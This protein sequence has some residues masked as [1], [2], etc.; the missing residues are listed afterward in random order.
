MCGII[1]YVGY[2]NAV[3]VLLYGLQ[4]LEYRGYDS[5]GIAVL[6][7]LNN[8]F[9]IEKKVGKIKDLQEHLW[10]KNIEG[11]IGIG[12]TRW[13]T[14]GEPTVENA[15]PHIS[16]SD[17]ITLVHNGIIENYAQL[18]EELIKKGYQFKSQ[19]DTEVV[20][21]LIEDEYK[22]NPDKSLLQIV[23]NV[24][25]K[26]KGAYA[27]GII[28]T[29]EPD[30]IIAVR[31]GSPLIIGV[32]ENENFIAS[33]IPAVLEY[34]KR[35]IT[36]DDDE[37]AVITKDNI[38]IYNI[39][40]EKVEKKPFTVNWDISVAEKAG[41]KHFML[42]EIY[43]QPRTITD[44]ITGFFSQ[45]NQE[46]YEKI[47]DIQ[48]IHIVACGT[49]YHAGLVGKFWIE[50]FAKIPVIVDYASE[51]R[52]RDLVI[53]DKTLVIAIS[54][55]GE[56]ADTRFAVLEAKKKGAKLL[57]I[58][59]VVGSSLSRESDYVLYTYCGP[60]IGVAAT[61]TFTAQLI[62]LLLFSLKSALSKNLISEK[63]FE[64]FYQDLIKLPSIIERELK[65]ID[66][67]TED[68]AYKYHNA[69]DFLFLGRG[70]NYPIALEGALKLKEISYIHA[71]GY[72]AGEMKHG[73]IALIDENMPV[74]SII[75]KDNLYEKMLSNIQEVKARKGK[76]IS[77]T[78]KGNKEVIEISDD[79]IEI[80]ETN[81]NLYP[82]LTAIP[83][84][85]LA[86]HIATILGKD[87]DQPRNLAKT[88]T[89][90]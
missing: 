61:K 76:V 70:L 10:G 55:S 32:G 51:Y 23:L 45:E 21:H 80:E 49:S 14:H 83:L 41:Y 30:K 52:Y 18:K 48:I 72:P 43:E 85:L 74:V 77:L 16:Q 78:T 53:N 63:Y 38:Q 28:S 7:R 37:I 36:L 34:T 40:G 57:S 82:I 35:F 86:Y 2:R 64:D 9:I 15:H 58:V 56:T 17:I 50:K 6:D 20:A 90:E 73:P 65:D 29:I 4:R 26:L 69:K 47:K 25:K 39:H 12:H 66:K 75:P 62:T 13:A 89:V 44:T 67:K 59:N 19:T 27:L 79:F 33:D 87:V 88:V 54:Q 71:E 8:K 3:P 84:Q 60:E 1:G 46:L 11:H 5:A 68:I 24:V 22:N 42:K 31:K 81:E